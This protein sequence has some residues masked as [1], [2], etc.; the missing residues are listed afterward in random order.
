MI[1]AA[2]QEIQC[3][4]NKGCTPKG[5]AKIESA[6]ILVSQGIIDDVTVFSS[7]PYRP[8]FAVWFVS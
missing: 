3:G 7:I 8:I 6:R 5:A 4:A 2:K 1:V